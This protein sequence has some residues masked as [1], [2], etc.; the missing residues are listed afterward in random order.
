MDDS[1][2]SD[3]G[4]RRQDSTSPEHS[5][6]TDPKLVQTAIPEYGGFSNVD[7]GHREGF[8]YSVPPASFI[9]ALLEAYDGRKQQSGRRRWWHFWGNNE[10]PDGWLPGVSEE[11]LEALKDSES[12]DQAIRILDVVSRATDNAT[13]KSYGKQI[14]VLTYVWLFL[15]LATVWASACHLHVTQVWPPR[16]EA[17][18]FS[19]SDAT[20]IALITTTTANVLGLT[21]VIAGY[22]FPAKSPVSLP[23]P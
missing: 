21:Y 23:K 6:S 9:E 5:Q 3:G 12:V 19:L 11:L 17:V 8:G 7:S 4:V 18:G 22:L 16:F 14:L 15:T 1:S 2:E 20:L 13:R 10:K